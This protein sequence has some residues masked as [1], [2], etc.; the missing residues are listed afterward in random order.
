MRF[1]DDECDRFYDLQIEPVLKKLKL[2]KM[3]VD[4]AQHRDDLN[5]FIIQQIRDA[6]I[7]IADLTHSRPSVYYESGYAE[8]QIPV[9]YTVR[10][11]HLGRGQSDETLRVHFDLQMKKIIGWKSAND[12]AFKGKL[13]ARLQYFL[14]DI[15]KR[16][17]ADEH[18]AQEETRFRSLSLVTRK[19]S[20]QSFVQTAIRKSGF[21]VR[22]LSELSRTRAFQLAGSSVS[23]GVK[24][25][26]RES[27]FCCV[28]VS[29]SFSKRYLI[30]LISS[31]Q[32]RSVLDNMDGIDQVHETYVLCSLANTPLKR[33]ASALPSATPDPKNGRLVLEVKGYADPP[34]QLSIFLLNSIKSISDLDSQLS[35]L[36]QYL[37]L[38]KTNH[39]IR[40]TKARDRS[41]WSDSTIIWVSKG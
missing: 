24:K 22:E 7:M 11:D 23:I 16:L 21:N 2:S 39:G 17:E 13:E 35:G 33:L 31:V 41:R 14:R 34:R 32:T 36:R 25:I 15:R 19:N 38:R 6:D 18:K 9:V 8:R 40:L 3:R 27:H 28:S 20:A 5:L 10:K 30:D 26:Q 12:S 4:R 1:G 37:P 29:E